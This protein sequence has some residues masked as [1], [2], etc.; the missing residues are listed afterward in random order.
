MDP[1]TLDY[2]QELT[3][4]FLPLLPPPQLDTV[5]EDR[6]GDGIVDEVPLGERQALHQISEQPEGTEGSM[7][8]V[9]HDTGVRLPIQVEVD[10]EA[11]VVHDIGGAHSKV[12]GHPDIW[13][14]Q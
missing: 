8:A 2:L 10:M 14:P 13:Q 12:Q 3:D 5:G 11:K 7:G 1:F 9:G 4:T 6:E